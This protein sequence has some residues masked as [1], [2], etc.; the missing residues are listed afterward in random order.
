MDVKLQNS[1]GGPG[2][3]GGG[4][5]P[6]GTFSYNDP[7]SGVS[8]QTSNISSLSFNDSHARFTGT[9]RLT[10]TSQISFF[11]DVTDDPTPGTVDS[12]S[13]QTG[14][15]YTAGGT[16]TSGDLQIH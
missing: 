1:N 9:A 6:T 3:G 10:R 8:F 11:V 2:G 14:N 4:T 12:F 5:T 7:A 13:I 15:G 16:L